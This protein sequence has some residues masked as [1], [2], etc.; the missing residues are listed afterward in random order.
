MGLL[1]EVI[2]YVIKVLNGTG[3]GPGPFNFYFP[4]SPGN[5]TDPAR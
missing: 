5:G 2:L 4:G 3:P 1:K